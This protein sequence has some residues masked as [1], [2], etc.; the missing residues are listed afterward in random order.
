MKKAL[1][2][3]VLLCMITIPVSAQEYWNLKASLNGNLVKPDDSHGAAFG[4]VMT[5]T[6]GV[7]DDDYEI[8]FEV[9][10]WWR[11]YTLADSAVEATDTTLSGSKHDQ[12]GLSFSIIG[13]Q[14]L[15]SLLDNNRLDLYG[16]GGG[17]FYFISENRQEARQ[18]PNTGLYSVEEVNNYLLTRGDLFVLLA[19]D[20]KIFPKLSLC[21]ENRFTYIFDWHEWDNPYTYGSSLGLRYDF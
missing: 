8:G 11:S 7:P 6:V 5:M 12:T 3:I 2:A 10:K 18:N 16:G 4:A 15:Y 19:F 17:G 20:T 13:R 1:L 14:K 9:S 21:W